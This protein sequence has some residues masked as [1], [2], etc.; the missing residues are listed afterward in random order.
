[1]S[2]PKF[3]IGEKVVIVC[4]SVECNGKV[5]VIRKHFKSISREFSEL[6]RDYCV[7]VEGYGLFYTNVREATKMDLALEE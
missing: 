4:D 6:M 5:G 7:Y 1:L 3:K 2:E